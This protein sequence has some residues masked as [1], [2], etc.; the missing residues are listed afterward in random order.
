[1]E[2][3]NIRFDVFFK[4]MLMGLADVVPGVSSGTIALITGVYEE[5]IFS[6]NSVN[7]FTFFVALLKKNREKLNKLINEINI[8]FLVTIGLGMAISFLIASKF[9][10]I[11]LNNYPV[12][13]Y[14]FFFGLI[15]VSA[16]KIF[17]RIERNAPYMTVLVTS[18]GS[19]IAFLLT[20]FDTLFSIHSYGIIF[21]GGAL[22]IMAMILPGISG[23]FMLLMIGQYEYMLNALHNFRSKSIDIVVFLTGAV[24]SLF[25]FADIISYF[26]NNYKEKV[27]GFL[28]GLMIGALRLPGE[29]IIYAQTN[30]QEIGFTWTLSNLFLSISFLLIG[31]FF[32][33]LIES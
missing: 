23:S 5:L 14:S 3:K 17:E 20:G 13:T 28:T 11:A 31:G 19:A 12:F 7:P 2:L 32:V 22:A 33:Y 15:L 24:I 29:K 27:L 25:A 10:L 30:Y 21:F 9:V 6:I 16:I 8:I 4:G 1:M 26:L 18:I